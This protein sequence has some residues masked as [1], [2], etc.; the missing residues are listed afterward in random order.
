VP[1]SIRPLYVHY[2]PLL[3]PCITACLFLLH[4]IALLY[5]VSYNKDN[6]WN[7]FL[8][9]SATLIAMTAL[10]SSAQFSSRYPYQA[11]PFLLLY[12]EKNVKFTRGLFARALFGIV[13]GIVSLFLFYHQ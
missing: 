4:I 5:Q 2:F 6:N 11:M 12:V 8:L 13:L 9:V 1:A 3:F 7:L 10:K